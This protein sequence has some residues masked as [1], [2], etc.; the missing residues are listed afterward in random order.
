MEIRTPTESER[1]QIA[2]VMSISLNFG[3]DWAE[4][5]AP[6]FRL[7][8]FIV[9]VEDGRVVASANPDVLSR[10]VVVRGEG[11]S[12]DGF[13]SFE[14]GK[15]EGQFDFSFGIETH[16]LVARSQS[17]LRSLFA[18]FRGFR[19]LGETL[20]WSGPPADPVAL[21]IEEQR[22]KP[23]WTFRWMLRLLDVPGAFEARGY[24]PVSGAADITLR[25]LAFPEDDG[26]TYHL[27][28]EAGKVRTS[29][30]ERPSRA[31]TSIGTFSSMFTSYTS[32]ADAARVGA[33]AADDATVEF[34]SALFAGPAPWLPEWF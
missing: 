14:Y 27:E 8:Q 10:T 5:R 29:R 19:G 25:D 4:R 26:A 30:V 9:A 23:A 18:Y 16:H 32:P 20:Q 24:P 17:A 7:E 1:E 15:T 21:L 6:T 12:V 28:A 2:S 34:L 3:R 31:T 22:M 13:C 11:G 33:M